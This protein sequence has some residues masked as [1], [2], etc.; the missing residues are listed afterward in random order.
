MNMYENK[1]RGAKKMSRYNLNLTDEI[2]M[3]ILRQDLL[4]Y[5][6]V[7]NSDIDERRDNNSKSLGWLLI[8]VSVFILFLIIGALYWKTA[9]AD[10][11]ITTK[12]MEI[13]FL[14]G[15]VLTINTIFLLVSV[16]LSLSH[17]GKN[18]SVN[19]FDSCYLIKESDNFGLVI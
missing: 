16:G 7:Y 17:K 12:E 11:K 2:E 5:S 9:Y 10:H 4:N 6:G 19:E 1:L 14:I 13:L 8:N 18:S 15:G 3:E